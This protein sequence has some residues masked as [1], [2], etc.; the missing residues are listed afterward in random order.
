M[1]IIKYR[2]CGT[3]AFLGDD[4]CPYAVSGRRA[5]HRKRSDRISSG[6]ERIDSFYHSEIIIYFY[7]EKQSSFFYA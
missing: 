4:G 5:Y 3:L 2:T 6:M 7:N 1:E